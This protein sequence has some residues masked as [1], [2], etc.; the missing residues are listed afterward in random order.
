MRERKQI[1]FLTVIL[2]ALVVL[3]GLVETVKAAEP[4]KMGVISAWDFIWWPWGETWRGDGNQGHK[5]S[6]IN[7]GRPE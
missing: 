4:I 5:F 6:E 1:V 7:S 3:F 2:C